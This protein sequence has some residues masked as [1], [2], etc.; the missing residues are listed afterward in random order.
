M[1]DM[2]ISGDDYDEMVRRL[3]DQF[4]GG[5]LPTLANGG[6]VGIVIPLKVRV[7]FPYLKCS[8]SVK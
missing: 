1:G 3:K 2:T 7:H 5:N 4:A 8:L 6:F